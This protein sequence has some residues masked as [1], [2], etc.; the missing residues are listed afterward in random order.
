MKNIIA[1]K[2]NLV[3]YE[4][5]EYFLTSNILMFFS[6]KVLLEMLSFVESTIYFIKKRLYSEEVNKKV[7][8]KLKYQFLQAKAN[9]FEM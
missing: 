4:A 8:N 7:Q 9:Y 5:C 2:N 1:L 6:S 3:L